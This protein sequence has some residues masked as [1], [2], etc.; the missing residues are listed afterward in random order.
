[1]TSYAPGPGGKEMQVLRIPTLGESKPRTTQNRSTLL[2]DIH[3]RALARLQP[4]G[5]LVVCRTQRRDRLGPRRTAAGTCAIQPAN[6][7]RPEGAALSSH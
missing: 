6:R 2:C 1:M 4:Q 5:T 7:V 3:I